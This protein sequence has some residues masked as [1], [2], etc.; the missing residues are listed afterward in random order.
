MGCGKS[1]SAENASSP[2]GSVEAYV[3]EQIAAHPLIMWSKTY[4]GFCAK[5]KKDLAP[6]KPHV[7]EVDN[8]P[9]DR[10]ITAALAK[11][12]GQ[13]T[14]PNVFCKSRHVGGSDKVAAEVKSGK[15]KT[16]LENS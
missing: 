9:D 6:F 10:A 4:C 12:T 11:K 13:R 16:S 3:D 1:S 8:S 7:I 5:A 14:F 15:M 2:A